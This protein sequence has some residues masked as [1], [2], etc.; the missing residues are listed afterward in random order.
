MSKS[1]YRKL[2]EDFAFLKEYGYFFWR[3]N[4][5]KICPSVAFRNNKEELRIGYMYNN[6][7]MYAYR[8]VPAGSWE[9]EDLLA[10]IDVHGSS[11]KEQVE[12]VREILYSYLNSN[13]DNPQEAVKKS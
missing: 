9:L 4:E 8:Y 10:D 5:H 1:D 7:Q 2:A 12:Q 11:Y 6:N 13:R 3:N